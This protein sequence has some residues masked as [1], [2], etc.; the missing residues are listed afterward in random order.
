[1]GVGE[2]GEACI[3][4]EQCEAVSWRN[5]ELA[6]WQCGRRSGS[7]TRVT[8]RASRPSLLFGFRSDIIGRKWTLGFLSVNRKRKGEAQESHNLP[9]ATPTQVCCLRVACVHGKHEGS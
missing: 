5:G 6:R 2:A 7:V 4:I 1:M 9:H 8:T 3:E